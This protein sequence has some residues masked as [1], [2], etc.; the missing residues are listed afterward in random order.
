MHLLLQELLQESQNDAADLLEANAVRVMGTV[1][2]S[3]DT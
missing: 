2:V 3:K 1:T